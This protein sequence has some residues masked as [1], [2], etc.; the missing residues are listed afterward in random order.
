MTADH[1]RITECGAIFTA[2]KP[3]S[4]IGITG[5]WRKNK[6]IFKGYIINFGSHSF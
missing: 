2:Q 6:G 4:Q 3:E 1:F 5:Q